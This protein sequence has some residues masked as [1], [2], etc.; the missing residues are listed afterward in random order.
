MFPKRVEFPPNEL[1]SCPFC[2]P[3]TSGGVGID[4]GRDAV[5]NAVGDG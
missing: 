3:T 2:E 1:V 5:G 4:A